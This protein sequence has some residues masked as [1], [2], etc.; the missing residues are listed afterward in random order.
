MEGEQERVVGMGGVRDV[1]S[2]QVER[3]VARHGGQICVQQVVSLLV[4]LS[5][6]DEPSLMNAGS[7][8]V[9]KI[10]VGWLQSGLWQRRRWVVQYIISDWASQ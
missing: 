3:G 9:Q 7:Q 8:L 2:P 4:E 10:L 1:E 5:V 6:M